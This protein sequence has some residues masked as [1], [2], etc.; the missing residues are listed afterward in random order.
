MK[1]SFRKKIE[2]IVDGK[3]N[4]QEIEELVNFIQCTFEN[5]GEESDESFFRDLAF[6]M[7]ASA[8]DLALLIIEY[9]RDLKDHID[10]GITDLTS[11]YIPEAADQLEGIMQTTES[12][13]NRIMD[14]LEVMQART[15]NLATIVEN[16]KQG[17]IVVPGEQGAVAET[18]FSKVNG[19]LGK[20]LKALTG[21]MDNTIQ[22]DLD[23]I[24]DIFTQMSFQDL[25]GQR[26][27]RILGLVRQ[28]EERLQRMVVS[29]GIKVAE[30]EKNPLVTD[31]ELDIAVAKKQSE[32]AGPQKAG[33][34]LDQA[35]ID[36]LLASI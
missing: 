11:V 9:R 10:P 3:L 12:V 22:S 28:M 31:Q 21:F 5:N 6:E 36:E 18:E 14:N 13:A 25:T 34:G 27:K 30:K 15:D 33:Y 16:L 8:K 2:D 19:K 29:F 32:L 7:S 1:G 4:Q 26:I 23:I 17:K 35:G 24:S 20:S